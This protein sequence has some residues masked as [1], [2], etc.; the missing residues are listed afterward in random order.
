LNIRRARR[1]DLGV[2][3]NI[4]LILLGC[5]LS[6]PARSETVAGFLTSRGFDETALRRRFGN[7]LY[8]RAPLN[9][10][11]ASLLLDSSTP[12]TV[13]HRDSTANYGIKV[14]PTTRAVRSVFGLTGD[15]YGSAS[16]RTLSIGREILQDVPVLVAD[17]QVWIDPPE[18]MKIPKLKPPAKRAKLKYF[19]TIMPVNGVVGVDLLREY[20]A[21]IDCG[22]QKLFTRKQYSPQDSDRLAG[23]LAER[24]FARIPM[25]LTHDEELEVE[26]TVNS[27]RT[28]LLVATGASF[29]FLGREAGYAAGVKAAP[30]RF[31]YP[32]ENSRLLQLSN[33]IAQ[34]LD[35]GSFTLTDAKVVLIDLSS[36]T[37]HTAEPAETNS[38]LLGMDLLS[39]NYA[40]IDFGNLTLYLRHPDHR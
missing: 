21:V 12:S 31:L 9:D 4:V 6:A 27:Q 19:Y 17:P 15:Y 26:A 10:K 5:A 18:Y 28:R 40:V 13:V 8:F 33:G 23:L 39:L 14:A 20:H 7:H 36:Q 2:R 24:G 32:L 11:P 22:H 37:L 3:F 38:G 1:R 35:I 29:T 25:R 30:S 16:L 34:A